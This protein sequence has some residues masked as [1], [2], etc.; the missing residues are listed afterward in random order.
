M[1]SDRL[2]NFVEDATAI[3]VEELLEVAAKPNVLSRV[4]SLFLHA[5]L[6]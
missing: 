4:S 1:A 6:A 5:F 3:A 2:L